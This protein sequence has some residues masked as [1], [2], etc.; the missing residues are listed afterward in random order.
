M[1]EALSPATPQEVSAV[2]LNISE[3]RS[4]L[5]V[6]YRL[7]SLLPV[8]EAPS[9]PGMLLHTPD[10]CPRAICAGTLKP[11]LASPAAGH[12]PFLTFFKAN[13]GGFLYFGILPE[14]FMLSCCVS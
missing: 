10:I 5:S 14:T 13:S 7:F 11:A 2:S 8:Q 4:E 1:A 12:S 3:D 6:T 9:F